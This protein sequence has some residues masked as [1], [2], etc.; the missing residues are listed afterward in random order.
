MAVQQASVLSAS[1]RVQFERAAGGD[2]YDA[3]QGAF[4]MNPPWRIS[5]RL[6]FTGSEKTWFTNAQLSQSPLA[7]DVWHTQ[8]KP[9]TMP[10]LPGNTHKKH[11]QY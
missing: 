1:A 5:T 8:L 7:L 2:W 10:N 6:F 4:V 9:T 11:Q 3:K